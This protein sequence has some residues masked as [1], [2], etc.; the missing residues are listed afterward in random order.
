MTKQFHKI[1]SKGV[2]RLR[3]HGRLLSAFGLTYTSALVITAAVLV[4]LGGRGASLPIDSSPSTSLDSHELS[5]SGLTEPEN[6]AKHD[7]GEPETTDELELLPERNAPG[8]YSNTIGS[9][10]KPGINLHPETHLSGSNER[11]SFKVTVNTTTRTGDKLPAKKDDLSMPDWKA[12]VT[13]DGSAIDNVGSNGYGGSNGIPD[14][15]ELYP[16]FEAGYV[17]EVLSNG[18][19]T[20]A[21]ALLIA[22]EM[23]NEVLYNGEVRREHDLGNAFYMLGASQGGN[24]RIYV[25]V[26]RLLSDFPTFIEFE[27]NQEL[28][29][30]GSGIPWWEIQ[31]TRRDGDLLVRFNLVAGKLTS[32]ELARWQNSAYHLF[33]SDIAGLG[34]GCI[35][36]FSYLYCM[37]APPLDRSSQ[38]IEVW[39]ANYEYVEP[40]L[41]NSFAELGLDVDRLGLAADDFS[42]LYIRTP[43][44]VVITSFAAIG[45]Q[46]KRGLGLY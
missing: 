20:D 6:H 9:R 42:G 46:A 24:L 8:I 13:P 7:T 29:Y 31:G 4:T 37:G 23:S 1:R 19:A 33:E 43:E 14:Y 17:E 39:D 30:I 3:C 44:D 15:L 11:S 16:A 5:G 18:I 21:S 27:F 34:S 25:G 38:L 10:A 22:R 35:D 41:A 2:N 32:V 26:E 12:I 28:V 36:R 40:T 45:S